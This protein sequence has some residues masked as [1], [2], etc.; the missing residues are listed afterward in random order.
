[1]S[2]TY[3]IKYDPNETIE[4]DTIQSNSD[5]EATARMLTRGYM[6]SK[7]LEVT[8]ASMHFR[9][10]VLVSLVDN[11]S[12][13]EKQKALG[14]LTRAMATC[15]DQDPKLA[16]YSEYA[17]TLALLLD[18]EDIAARIIARNDRNGSGQF[19]P[20]LATVIT[21][22]VGATAFSRMIKQA[23]EEAVAQWAHHR[24]TLFPNG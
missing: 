12:D 7:L 15:P 6:P 16:Y 8:A 24:P 23:G 20:T 1:M 13:N 3:Q 2:D 4:L 9:D 14:I 11:A 21:R 17:A 18:K 19:L 22:K 10:S 5:H